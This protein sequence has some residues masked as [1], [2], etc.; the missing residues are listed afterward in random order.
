MSDGG[1]TTLGLLN[2]AAGKLLLAVW[3]TRTEDTDVA[4]D[5]TPYITDNA[6]VTRTYPDLAGFDCSLNDGHLT[7]GFPKGNCAAYVEISL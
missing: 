1:H 6:Q 4:V 2:K 5:L 3:Q 7:V